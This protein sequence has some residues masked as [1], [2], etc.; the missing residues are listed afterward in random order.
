MSGE[1]GH[2][3]GG[4]CQPELEQ[5]LPTSSSVSPSQPGAST[6]PEC[7][8]VHADQRQPPV[9]S[10]EARVSQGPRRARLRVTS[11]RHSL[12]H[13]LRATPNDPQILAPSPD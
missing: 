11:P 6:E 9:H 7:S 2:A 10:V 8:C 12:L 4:L 5:P 13:P 3:G 1:Q